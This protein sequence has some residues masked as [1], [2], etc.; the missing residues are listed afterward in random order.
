MSLLGNIA[1]GAVT[2][3]SALNPYTL[4]QG[5]AYAITDGKIGKDITPGFS[6][7]NVARTQAGNLLSSSP[8]PKAPS[9]IPQYVDPG[10]GGG[11]A[12]GTN[13]DGTFNPITSGGVGGAGGVAQGDPNLAAQYE[14]QANS[15][16]GQLGFLDGQLTNG[17]QTIDNSYGQSLGSLNQQQDLAK[18][19]YDTNIAQNTRDYSSTRNNAVTQV[20]SQANALQRLLGMNG[21][22]NSSAAFEQAPYAAALQGSQLINN[23][24]SVYSKNAANADNNWAQTQLSAKQQKDRLD[25][26]KA[27]QQQKL[28][29]DV[30]NSKA[31]LLDQIRQANINASM[32]R[33]SGY[34]TAAANQAGLQN[35]ISSLLQQIQNIGHVNPLTFDSSSVQYKTPDMAQYSLDGAT[36]P[37]SATNGSDNV[38]PTFLSYLTG[39]EKKDQ[40]GNPIYA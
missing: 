1:K 24:Q 40:F 13:S 5:A 26:S 32:A 29:G 9:Q 4:G 14:D 6:A 31:T 23:A 2:V 19:Q 35:Q 21:A 8:A 30:A 18:H 28:Q 36:A 17:Q 37:T 20:R 27:Q 15:L 16:Q 3:G 33:G 22:G 7:T 11:G 25:Q 10:G 39:N 38:D 12:S 34:Q